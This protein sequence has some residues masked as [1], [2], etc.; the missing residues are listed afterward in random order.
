MYDHILVPTDGSENTERAIERAIEMA[1]THGATLHALYV[2]HSSAIAP[3]IDF[4]DLEGVGRQA[5][6]HVEERA[7]EAGVSDVRTTVRHGLRHRAI[8]DYADENDVDLIVIGRHKSLDHL[9]RTSL[10][11]KVANEATVPVLVVE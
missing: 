5:V 6:D 7:V 9:V 2:I 11:K 8:F 1:K 4:D 10:S 3:G